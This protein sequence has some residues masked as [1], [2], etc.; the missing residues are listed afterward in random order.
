MND[1]QNLRSNN[2]SKNLL[3]LPEYSRLVEISDLSD[4]ILDLQKKLSDSV[5]KLEQTKNQFQ[6]QL[7]QDE[8]DI[9]HRLNIVGKRKAIGKQIQQM[10][11]Q[12]QKLKKI[13]K[14]KVDKILSGHKDLGF[15]VDQEAEARLTQKLIS[16]VHN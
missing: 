1:S 12:E 9:H 11:E 8:E 13:I 15:L 16:K 7:I 2:S 4:T 14:D 10:R 5:K 6:L 3:N